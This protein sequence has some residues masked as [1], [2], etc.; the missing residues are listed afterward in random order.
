ML[1]NTKIITRKAKEKKMR[2][3][4]LKTKLTTIITIAFLVTS[5]FVLI[6]S[7][8]QAQ[9]NNVQEGGSI[10]LPAGVTPDFEVDTNVFLS[11]R[12]DPVGVGQEILV[13]LWMEPPIHVSRYMTGYQI[14]ITAPDGTENVIT[15]DS[16]R[17]DSTAWF[18][19]IVDQVGTWKIRFDFP[20]AFFP[21]GNYTV[22]EGIAVYLPRNIEFTESCYYK[23]ATTGDQE[24]TGTGRHCVLL[25]RSRSSNRL[26]DKTHTL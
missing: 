17:G 20:G 26:L 7:L 12:P 14:T 13:N 6:T 23:P 24:L 19:W 3:N 5:A 16:Y 18:P 11:F 4:N 8:V 22:P 9:Y 2:K 15:M 21:A 10:P 25:A 1:F